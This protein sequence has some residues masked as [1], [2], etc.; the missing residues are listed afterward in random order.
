MD[1]RITQ[2]PALLGL[3]TTPPKIELE[4]TPAVLQRH[5]GSSELK[6]DRKEPR[7]EIDSSPSR[8]A[9]GYYSPEAFTRMVVEKGKQMALEGI[10]RRAAEGSE[11]V[12]VHKN[13]FDP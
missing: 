9:M 7:L 1:I 2:Q 3:R 11:M 4:T 8:E 6:V 5:P 13:G 10:G 12:D